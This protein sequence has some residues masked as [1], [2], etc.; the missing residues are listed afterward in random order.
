MGDDVNSKVVSED[1][2]A[3]I[4]NDAS[5]DQIVALGTHYEIISC[6]LKCADFWDVDKTQILGSQVED[7]FPL[8]YGCEEIRHAID[9]ALNGMQSFVPHDKAKYGNV[10]FEHHFIPIRENG[11]DVSGVLI[12]IHD[13]AHRIKAE[14]ELKRL[15]RSLMRKNKTIEQHNAEFASFSYI[16]AHDLKEPLRK[17][18]TFIELILAQEKHNLSDNGKAHFR[19]IQSSAQRMGLLTDDLLTFTQLNDEMKTPLAPVDTAAVLDTVIKSLDEKMQRAN[20]RIEADHLPVIIGHAGM[21]EH[22]F[23]HILSNALKFQ[24]KGNEPHILISS[25][26]IDGIDIAG[27]PVQSDGEY[28]KLSFTDNGIGIDNQYLD[29]IFQMFQRLNT[30]QEYPGNGFGLALCKKIL[31]LHYGAITVESEPETGCTFN[32]YFPLYQPEL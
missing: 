31:E 25:S 20:A 14:N 24:R 4:L 1:K 8:L 19:R 2:L 3:T 16:A 12:I 27:A 15:N 23:R 10:Y 29:K 18:Y 17:I 13:V 7:V 21:I 6:N 5:I 9:H 32:C 22:L 28:I 26:V 11:V 30:R